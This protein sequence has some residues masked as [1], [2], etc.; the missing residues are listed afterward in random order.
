MTI[1]YNLIN[2]F[3]Q[4]LKYIEIERNYFINNNDM[5]NALINKFRISKLNNTLKVIKSFTTQ[6]KSSEELKNIKGIGKGS[7]SKIQEIIDFG[8]LKELNNYIKLYKKQVKIQKII[9]ELT[10]IIGIGP[11]IAYKLINTYNI[12]S[13]DDLKKRVEKGEIEVND[14]LKLGL[15]YIGKFQGNIPHSEIQLIEKYLLNFIKNYHFD[16][17][18]LTICGSYRR[19]L[20]FS[21]DI[22]I[23][24]TNINIID[25]KDHN[26]SNILNKFIIELKKVGFIIDDITG[27]DTKTKYMGFC[28]YKNKPIRRIDIRFVPYISYYTALLYFTGS[29]TLNEIMRNKAKKLGYK[30]SE[31]GLIK[32][33]NNELIY[34][35]SELEIFDLLDMKYLKPNERSI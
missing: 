22:D 12:K 17:T 26:K 23:L 33:S 5:K 19:E 10:S 6:I 35:E 7:L 28:K 27:D 29:Y 15:K 3:E 34:V 11:T 31:Y 18:I 4:L 25:D 16:D 21:S 30:L 8:K 24:L 9:D 20:P 2:I 1:N 13:I 14:K 32:L